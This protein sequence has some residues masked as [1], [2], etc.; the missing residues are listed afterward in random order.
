MTIQAKNMDQNTI[1]ELKGLAAEHLWIPYMPLPAYRDPDNVHVYVSGEGCHITDAEGKI[2]L[3]AFAGLM[4]KNVGYGRKEIADAA[5]AQMLEL[6]S[7]AQMD[8]GTVPAVRLAAK[9]AEI[10]PGSLSRSFFVSGGTEANEV[11]VKAAKQYQ[12]AAGFP[13]RY[14][15]IARDGEYHGYSH[16]AMTLGRADG[17]LYSVFEPLVPGVRHI[18]HPYCYRC[19]LELGYPDCGIA[20]AKDLERV[21][22]QENP[23]HVAAFL[24][25]AIS[26]QTPIAVPPAEYWPMIRSICD[27]YG[28]LLIDDEVV[29]GFGR[30][31]KMFGIE[32]FGVT[33]DIMT[34]AKGITSGYQPL[35]ACITAK[36]IGDKFIEKGDMFR[37]VTTFGGLPACCAA[38]LANIDIIEKEKLVERTA[39][40]GD[41]VSEKIKPLADYPV[42]GDIRGLGLMWGIELVKDRKTKEK[43]TRME[44]FKVTAALRQEGLITRVDDGI[45]RFMPP[46]II[47]EAEID[48]SFAIIEKVIG[49]M[50][51]GLLA[52]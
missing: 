46:L 9:L 4:Y 29:C 44:I 24:T 18:P 50:Q 43:L 52:K 19:P 22:V 7:S 2:Y 51:D 40:I 30:T 20:C 5:Y 38:G 32:Q 26:Q 6:T 41:Y 49:Q 11:A 25:V 1:D 47:S 23:K 10:T 12:Q 14:K 17:S 28:V 45:I 31:G 8:V 15:I 48:E 27:K 13:N 37:N 33:P 39:V 16:L 42:V 36:E 35:G 34:L 21:I 3:D